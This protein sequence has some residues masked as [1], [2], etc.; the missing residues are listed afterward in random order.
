[1]NEKCRKRKNKETKIKNN[2]MCER[3]NFVQKLIRRKNIIGWAL[4]GNFVVFDF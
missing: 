2:G 4:D 3:E 1:M